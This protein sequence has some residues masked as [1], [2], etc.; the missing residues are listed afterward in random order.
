MTTS[1]PMLLPE[2]T[3][4]TAPF[5]E[6]CRRH[7][8]RIQRCCDCDRYYFYP[9]PYC[10]HCLSE[11]TEWLTVSGE[12][13][14][15]TYV[16]NHRPMPGFTGEVP[17]VTAIVQLTEGPRLMT[18]LVG[19][20]ALPVNLPAGLPVTVVFDDVTDTVTLPRFTPKAGR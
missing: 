11:D 15:H 3:P 5:W 17:Y 18:N 9:R 19:V 13:T 7:E 12:G 4:E 1:Y 8:L 16:I 14:L 2:P 20:E 10:P 6:G